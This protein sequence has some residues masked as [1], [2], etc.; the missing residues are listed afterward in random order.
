MSEAAGGAVT[1][2]NVCALRIDT[3]EGT[4]Y[5]INDLR[6]R[7]IGPANGCVKIAGPVETDARAEVV[8]LDADGRLLKASA[9]GA[10]FI[11]LHAETIW[12]P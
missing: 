5:Y 4:D 7:E 11:K 2:A 6:Q 3:D 9:V 8:R 12:R 1:A 10:S